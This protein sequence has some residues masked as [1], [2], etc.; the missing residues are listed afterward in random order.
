[1]NDVHSAARKARAKKPSDGRLKLIWLAAALGLLGL[2]A[3]IDA[4]TAQPAFWFGAQAFMRA[5][6]GAAAA[7]VV[8][9][10]AHLVRLVLTRRR[11]PEKEE[12]R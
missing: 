3:A 11:G 8:I 9:L 10:S 1:M 7:F 2:S 5:A 6:I 12:A 4:L